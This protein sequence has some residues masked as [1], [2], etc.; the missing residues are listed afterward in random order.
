MATRYFTPDEANA[1]LEEVRPVAEALVAHRH[2]MAAAAARRAELVQRI[3]GNGGDFD[4]QEPRALEEEVERE[5][6]AGTQSVESPERPRV[7]RKDPH[8]G[9]GGLSALSRGPGGAALLHPRA[10]G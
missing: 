8:P 4:P 10:G 7:P 9:P 3:A 2:A 5:S 6:Q 1:H